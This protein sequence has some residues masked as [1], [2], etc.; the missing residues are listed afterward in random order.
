LQE[1]CLQLGTHRQNTRRVSGAV[2]G[3]KR[4]HRHLF[5]H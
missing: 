2:K 3:G 5:T 4:S 1:T